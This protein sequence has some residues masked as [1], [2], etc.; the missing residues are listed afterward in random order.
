MGLPLH[1]CPR[2]GLLRPLLR[3]CMAVMA[4]FSCAD[5][6]VH[7][8]RHVSLYSVPPSPSTVSSS[9]PAQPLAR[10]MQTR[11]GAQLLAERMEETARSRFHRHLHALVRTFEGQMFY[12][13]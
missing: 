7:M 3:G 5:V 6:P 12:S 1:A 10:P 9:R 11:S 2:A 4:D 8:A 13:I